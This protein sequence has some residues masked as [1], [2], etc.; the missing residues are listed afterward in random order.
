MPNDNKKKNNESHKP[1]VPDM[2]PSELAKIFGEDDSFTTYSENTEAINPLVLEDSQTGEVLYTARKTNEKGK[3]GG[4][5]RKDLSNCKSISLDEFL[6]EREIKKLMGKSPTLR[7]LTEQMMDSD[8]IST[9]SISL[10]NELE[11]ARYSDFY[12]VLYLG[13]NWSS[14]QLAFSLAHEATFMLERDEVFKEDLPMNKEDFLSIKMNEEAQALLNQALINRQIDQNTL[15][16][17]PNDYDASITYKMKSRD[18]KSTIKLIEL[19]NF[20][21]NGKRLNLN[22]SFQQIMDFICGA[23]VF[24][25]GKFMNFIIHYEAYW[26]EEYKPN[27]FKLKEGLGRNH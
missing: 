20:D 24:Q 19:L 1:P 27:Y 5:Q 21:D 25:N 23:L 15:F 9:F 6:Q 7:E 3:G 22:Q 26:K 2:S 13:S 10:V 16:K 4:N 18:D 12:N 11:T 8:W 17:L 14:R